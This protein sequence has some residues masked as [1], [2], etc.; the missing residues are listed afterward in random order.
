MCVAVPDN[1]SC[2]D[3]GRQFVIS[4]RVLAFPFTDGGSPDT[5]AGDAAIRQNV[6]PQDVIGSLVVDRE[7]VL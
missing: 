2:I 5:E 3:D 6:E 4:G 7:K 1:P